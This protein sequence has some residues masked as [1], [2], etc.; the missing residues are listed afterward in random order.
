[1]TPTEPG[2]YWFRE[3]SRTEWVPARFYTGNSMV[4]WISPRTG[5]RRCSK[6]DRRDLVLCEWGPP[7]E[8]PENSQ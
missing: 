8:P 6:I 7:I 2:W 4:V 5:N 1:M 3:S